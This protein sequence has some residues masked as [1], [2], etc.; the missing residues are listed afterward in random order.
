MLKS[1]LRGKLP[2]CPNPEGGRGI[3]I[4]MGISAFSLPNAAPVIKPLRLTIISRR[5]KVMGFV[6]VMGL[7]WHA[8]GFVTKPPVDRP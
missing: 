4:W 2:P 6:L 3:G 7:V 5:V 1:A 8:G